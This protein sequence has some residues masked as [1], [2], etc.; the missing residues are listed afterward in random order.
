MQLR[1]QRKLWEGLDGL[2]PVERNHRRVE[3]EVDLGGGHGQ[4]R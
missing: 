4:V 1:Q 2:E 3:V